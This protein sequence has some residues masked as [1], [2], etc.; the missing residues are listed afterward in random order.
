MKR[1]L[2]RGSFLITSADPTHSGRLWLVVFD[3][4]RANDPPSRR[5]RLLPASDDVVRRLRASANRAL[6]LA[7]KPRIVLAVAEDERADTPFRP[8]ARTK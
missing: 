4:K 1:G 7:M 5:Q 8:R 6:H 2:H 3:H